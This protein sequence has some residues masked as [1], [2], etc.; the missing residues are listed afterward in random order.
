[1]FNQQI[2]TLI[3]QSAIADG[4]EPTAFAA[5]AQVESGGIATTLVNGHQEPLIR[6]EGH[7]FD[8]R[9]NPQDQAKARKL[10]LSSPKAGDIANPNNQADRWAF[11]NRAC[12]INRNAAYE[13]TSWGIGQVMGAHWEWLGYANVLALVQEV[14]ASVQGQI[15]LMS[16]FI[17][18]SNLSQTL[19]NH[20]WSSIARHYNGP[21]YA[22]NRYD[23]KLAKAC[24]LYTDP[25][26]QIEKNI[27]PHDPLIA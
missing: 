5:I 3:V 1:M 12:S 17:R 25:V 26:R 8:R 23:L 24:Q 10:H 7:Y 14:R 18:H 4:L 13:S 9:L 19:N 27:K 6:F 11:L 20:E 21:Q 15:T 2:L 22:K 16:R